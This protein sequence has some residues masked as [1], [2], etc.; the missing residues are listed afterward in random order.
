MIGQCEAL[1][2]R[3]R[4]GLSRNS[5]LVRLLRMPVSS[6]GP[7]RDGLLLI[8][9]DGLARRQLE[10]A[11]AKNRMPFLQRLLEHE[12][13]RL[14]TMY[15][16]VPATTPAV[17]GELFYGVAQAVPAFAFRDSDTGESVQMYGAAIARRK[18]SELEKRTDHPLLCGGSAYC[19]VYSGGSAEA[20]CCAAALGW[21]QLT[22][23]IRP[24][25]WLIIGLLYT[26]EIARACMLAWLELLVA[27]HDAA[28]GSF[29]RRHVPQELGFVT[30]RIVACVILRELSTIAASLDAARGLPIVAVNFLGYDEQAHHRGPDARHAHRSLIGID[31]AIARISRAAA[32]SPHRDF[33]LWVY[34]DHGQENV[35]CYTDRYGR[36]V[37]QAVSDVFS[38]GVPGPSNSVDAQAS[39]QASRASYLRASE[40]PNAIGGGA[41]STSGLETIAVGPLGFIYYDRTLSHEQW[42][43]IA[44]ALV[45]EAGVPLVL[46][47]EADGRARAWAPGRQGYLPE[48]AATFLGSDHP[49][50]Q[51][52]A[53]DLVRLAHHR[54]A[55]DLIIGGWAAGEAPLTF[56]VE[57][58]AHAGCGPD[59]LSAFALLPADAPLE[60]ED[61]RIQRPLA[62]R[63]AA[64]RHARGHMPHRR[65]NTARSIR[66]LRVMTYNIHSCIGMDGRTVPARVA[67]VIATAGA[68]VVALQEVDVGRRRSGRLHQARWLADQLGMHVHFHCTLST[69]E[70]QYGQAVLSRWPLRIVRSGLLPISLP[71]E[72]EPRGAL[73][74][75]LNV[76]GQAV[77]MLSTHLG[78]FAQERLQ[79][80]D[81][82]LG[83][84]WLGSPACRDPVI[85]CGDLNAG[86]RSPVYRRLA[87]QLVDVQAARRNH[88]PQ[89]T[90][91]SRWPLRRIDHIFTR[92][93]WD[94]K[95]VE[96]LRNALTRKASDHLPLLAELH[97]SKDPAAR[98]SPTGSG[99]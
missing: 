30:R 7:E 13:Y 49:H 97:L 25:T 94:V 5:W 64:L 83:P 21:G 50:L 57:R 10:A 74:V 72:L 88:C 1:L 46:L 42:K 91:F 41:N 40:E 96:V 69:G 38:R 61:G 22:S 16:G 73:W 14:H 75:E 52:A 60:D 27:L 33:D 29:T 28:L 90:F 19:H 71:R 48:D 63:T 24:W 17:Q 66:S 6:A 93:R 54:D 67:R 92:G 84:E 77:Q 37:Q 43:Q 85:F 2:R 56:V 70:E 68:D 3:W 58:G 86:P 81:I 39:T 76:D 89:N 18:Q 87:G 59:E 26:P 51:P 55:G 11:L 80:T 8:Q 79:Q 98:G 95:H 62:L 34:S 31:N 78:L 44:A 47:A 36:T 65:Q 9:I 23:D 15:A 12:S 99:A 32:R 45:E 4:H 82:L 20:H 53:E 35:T